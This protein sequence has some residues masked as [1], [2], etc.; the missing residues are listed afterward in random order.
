VPHRYHA[1]L[2][3]NDEDVSARVSRRAIATMSLNGHL[4]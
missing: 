4:L 3:E 1:S 2:N